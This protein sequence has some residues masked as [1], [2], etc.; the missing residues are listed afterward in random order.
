MRGF[1]G[2]VWRKR[3]AGAS[4]EPLESMI[5]DVIGQHPEYQGL[6]QEPDIENREFPPEAVVGNPFLHMGLHMAI[7]EQVATDRPAGIRALY[8]SLRPR[9]PGPHDLEH[10]VMDCLAEFLWRAQSDG[11]A[12]DESA[13]LE[14]V[15]DLKKVRTGR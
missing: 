11:G 14:C 2:E 8:S 5:A 3:L 6:F 9:F 1:Y 10:A 13:Y 12:P 4:L 7:H 15:K